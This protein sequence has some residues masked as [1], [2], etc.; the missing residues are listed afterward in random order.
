MSEVNWLMRKRAWE[1]GP[2]A[3][4]GL[5]FGLIKIVV[6][7]CRR[8]PRWG[9]R[10][11]RHPLR[12]PTS[13]LCRTTHLSDVYTAVP[14]CPASTAAAVPSGTAVLSVRLMTA[15]TTVCTGRVRAIVCVVVTRAS[16]ASAARQ[17]FVTTTASPALA[18]STTLV[19]IN[20]EVLC[21]GPGST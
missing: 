2:Q 20:S 8:F 13:L 5:I 4:S 9:F 12:L 17:T 16:Q 6:V 18:L 10:S 1:W 14:F 21:K 3:E 7:F 15:S 11:R 19:I